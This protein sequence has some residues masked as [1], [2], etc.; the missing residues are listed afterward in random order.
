MSDFICAVSGVHQSD[1]CN[2]KDMMLGWES[3]TC[4]NGDKFYRRRIN[5]Q[6]W[7]IASEICDEYIKS[8]KEFLD[9]NNYE[10]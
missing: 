6:E 2:I 8:F 1:K 4:S 5:N 7:R 10:Y 3:H 9:V